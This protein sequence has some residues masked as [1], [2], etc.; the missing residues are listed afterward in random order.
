MTNLPSNSYQETMPHSLNTFVHIVQYLQPNIDDIQAKR[1]N[2]CIAKLDLSWNTIAPHVVLTH[3]HCQIN[4]S[5]LCAHIKNNL[6]I[7]LEVIAY[8]SL[9]G[10]K[11]A[12][13]G[14]TQPGQL[15]MQPVEGTSN[16]AITP[17]TLWSSVSHGGLHSTAS[18]VRAPADTY[19]RSGEAQVRTP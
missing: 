9:R 10:V 4:H 1:I 16:A 18:A 3:V 14:F 15:Q 5:S 13:E 11:L 12:G 17:P 6:Y 2:I 7:L 19:H 8:F